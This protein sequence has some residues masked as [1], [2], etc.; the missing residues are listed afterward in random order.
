RNRLCLLAA[1][2]ALSA[3]SAAQSSHPATQHA[4]PQD[5]VLFNSDH[6]PAAPQENAARSLD[7]PTDAERSSLT[8]TAY[9]LDVHLIPEKSQLAVRAKLTVRNSGTEPLAR[10]ALQLSSSLTW[11]SFGMQTSDRILPLSFVQHLIDTDTDHT[12][13]AKE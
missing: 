13:Q 11:E 4:T 9:D 5:Q 1:S 6:P 2:L 10:L 8:F 3:L 7:T 12:G